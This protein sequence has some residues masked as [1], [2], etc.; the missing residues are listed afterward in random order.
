M[1]EGD[2]WTLYIP[3]DFGYGSTAYSSIPAN[4]TLIFDVALVK[5]AKLKGNK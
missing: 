5:V 2:I 4:S 1:K 3:S